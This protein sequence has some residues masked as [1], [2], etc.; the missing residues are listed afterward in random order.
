MPDPINLGLV[1]AG[2]I[3]GAYLSALSGENAGAKIVAVA[4]VRPDAAAEFARRS[5][6]RAFSSHA[7]LERSGMCDAIILCTPPSTHADIAIDLLSRRIPVLCE[8]PL[9]ID[10]ASTCRMLAAAARNRTLLGMASKFRSVPA[11]AAAARLIEEGALGAPIMVENAFSSCIDMRRRWN[12]DP[13]V[14]GGGVIIDNGT[15]S[16]DMLRMLCGPIASVLASAG[17]GSQGLPVEETAQLLLRFTNGAVGRVALSWSADLMLDWF[18]RIVGTEGVAEVGWRVSRMRRNGGDWI[19]FSGGYDKTEAFR[20]QI[21]EFCKALRGESNALAQGEEAFH[22]VS[23]I[24][25]AYRSLRLGSWVT[26]G[27]DAPLAIAAAE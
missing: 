17:S 22:S 20:G 7:D 2:A 24:Q 18:V 26:I 11:I 1:G 13:A 12:S 4:D 25:A 16:A 3:A 15:H 19:Q 10:E 9:S 8:K 23:V 27:A 5:A 6:A 21:V 14:S